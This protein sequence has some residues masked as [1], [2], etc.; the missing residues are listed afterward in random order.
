MKK[1]IEWFIDPVGLGERLS[2][3]GLLI[4]GCMVL[5]KVVV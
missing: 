3:I 2:W 4:V 5:V 1:L